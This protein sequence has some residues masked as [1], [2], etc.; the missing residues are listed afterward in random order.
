[1][2]EAQITNSILMIRPTH[3]KKNDQTTD[4]YFQKDRTELDTSQSINKTAQQEFDTFVH[5][6]QSA[7]INVVQLDD[8]RD[9][10][11]DS[12][13]PNN[14][15]SFHSN[16]EVVL[17]PMRALNR[18]KERRA[19]ILDQ[20]KSRGFAINR[21]ITDYTHFEDE[22]IYLE[23]TGCIIFDRPHRKFYCSLSERSS[24]KLV[25]QYAKDFNLTPVTFKAYQT[26]DNQRKLI[27]HT[28]VMMCVGVNFALVCLDCIDD[29]E[30]RE[31][32]LHHLQSDGK[33][34]VAITSDQIEKFAGNMLQLQGRN[35]SVIVMSLSAYN[36][37][38]VSQK[39][40]L[41]KHGEIIYSDLHTI[42][43]FGG[44]SARCMMA[45]IF[46]PKI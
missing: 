23:G 21:L 41:S 26:V 2:R 29:K 8:L 45:E 3:F 39:A 19:D 14:W 36:A 44:G 40:T 37:L 12:V 10:T 24:E 5:K 35:G 43:K 17:Y 46:L 27:Y 42:E 32:L 6:L 13:F 15:V 33:E 16:G 18:R 34:V 25:I 20:L 4:N 9:D 30:E 7:G 22:D 38:T 11:P 31:N 28:N 1:M